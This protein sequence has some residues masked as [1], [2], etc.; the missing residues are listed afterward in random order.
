MEEM[1]V[2]VNEKNEQ[3]GIVPKATVHTTKTSLHR[4]F[5][6]FLFNK[7]GQFL[8]TRRAYSKKTFPGVLTNSFC[9]HP[10]P[11][12]SVTDAAKR[13]AVDELGITDIVVSSPIPYRY[14]AV[15]ASGIVENEICPV[16]IGTTSQ[17]PN[18]NPQE[19][20][21]FRFVS[22]SDFLS[23]IKQRPDKYSLWCKEEALLVDKAMKAK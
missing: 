5:S 12:E 6:V 1:V 20:A 22:W 21:E 11:N 9:G 18:M 13:R 2:L 10:A 15:D 16:M 19:V 17:E 8:V 4:G 23:D 3:L 14:R 7:K